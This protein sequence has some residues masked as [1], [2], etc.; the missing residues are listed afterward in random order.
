LN[1]LLLLVAG[2]ETEYLATV[3]AEAALVVIA[4]LL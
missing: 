2:V 1:T 4:P 3:E